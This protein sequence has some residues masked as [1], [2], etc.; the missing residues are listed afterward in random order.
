ME[1]K[2]KKINKKINIF[3]FKYYTKKR[4][5][6]NEKNDIQNLKLKNFYKYE[7]LGIEDAI[8]GKHRF[9]SIKCQSKK[10]EILEIK[11]SDFIYFCFHRNININYLKEIIINLKN[12]LIGKI[13][14]NLI[15]NKNSLLN[16]INYDNEKKDDIKINENNYELKI[17]K[18]ISKRNYFDDNIFDPLEI[19]INNIKKYKNNKNKEKYNVLKSTP[20]LIYYN[21]NNSKYFKKSNFKDLFLDNFNE[22][23][24]NYK[25]NYKGSKT[26][27]IAL[28]DNNNDNQKADINITNENMDNKEIN[29]NKE[30]NNLENDINMD[31]NVNNNSKNNIEKNDNIDYNNKSSLDIKKKTFLEILQKN[32]CNYSVKINKNKKRNER[33]EIRKKYLIAKRK[34]EESYFNREKIYY[35]KTFKNFPF[36]KNIYTNNKKANIYTEESLCSK[37]SKDLENQKK[38]NDFLKKLNSDKNVLFS[39]SVIKEVG[40]YNKNK[41]YNKINIRNNKKNNVIYSYFKTDYRKANKNYDLDVCFLKHIDFAKNKYFLKTENKI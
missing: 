40:Y 1:D 23:S 19:A 11:M 39:K 37:I 20:N 34:L 25:I 31:S 9:T 12:I 35:M 2:E 26:K 3:N 33:E 16:T 14:K 32:K 4:E 29:I 28:N 5:E 13:E 41:S 8:E 22:S 21:K 6:E 10:G 15:I 38:L 27:S 36:I 18:K 24:L 17:N 30:N 7:V